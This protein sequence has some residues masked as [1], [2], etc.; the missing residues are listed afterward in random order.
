MVFQLSSITSKNATV[1]FGHKSSNFFWQFFPQQ[2]IR[3]QPWPQRPR[4]PHWEDPHVADLWS[5]SCRWK[6]GNSQ[7][8]KLSLNCARIENSKAAKLGLLKYYVTTSFRPVHVEYI[9]ML[10]FQWTPPLHISSCVHGRVWASMASQSFGR[11]LVY[12]ERAG[13]SNFHLARKNLR[14]LEG[15]LLGMWFFYQQK[16]PKS[17][18]TPIWGPSQRSGKLASIHT[19]RWM[20]G[21]FK[22]VRNSEW[23][24][25]GMKTNPRSIL[26][27]HENKQKHDKCQKGQIWCSF[28]FCIAGC[29]SSGSSCQWID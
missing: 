18:P 13:G 7:S 8:Y 23:L 5:V 26:T 16:S 2:K 17:Q 3:F 10:N 29:Q 22:S 20:T 4:W 12:C 27:M 28:C 9:S 15:Q 19:L 24:I 11:K 1:N 25:L 6:G 14:V 21:G